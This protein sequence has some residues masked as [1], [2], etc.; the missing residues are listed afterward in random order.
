MRVNLR[1][2]AGAG[3]MRIGFLRFLKRGTRGFTL[4]ELLAVMAIIGIS[5][6]MVAGAV[7]GL[8]TAGINAQIV[9]DT[10][11]IET[12]SDRFLN[13]SFPATYPAESLPE[14][15]E[16]LGVRGINFDA[17]LVRGSS[18]SQPVRISCGH[19]RLFHRLRPFGACRSLGK[20]PHVRVFRQSWSRI[21]RFL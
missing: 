6:G 11:V 13:A 7:T 8:G 21:R 1:L 3:Q 18:Q 5:S 16:E 15:E 20:N 19:Q 17:R 14:G 12:A 4:V 9:S 2:R 10:K